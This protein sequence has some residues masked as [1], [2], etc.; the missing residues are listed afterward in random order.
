[1]TSNSPIKGHWKERKRQQGFLSHFLWR[2]SETI[3][4]IVEVNILKAF[5]SRAEAFIFLHPTTGRQVLF[6]DGKRWLPRPVFDL[7]PCDSWTETSFVSSSDSKLKC[8]FFA[9]H[10]FQMLSSAQLFSFLSIMLGKLILHTSTDWILHSVLI[11][12]HLIHAASINTDTFEESNPFVDDENKVDN[13]EDI[14]LQRRMPIEG[15]LLGRRAF[16][17]EGILLGKRAY[18]TEGIL[19]GKRRF[20][21]EGILLGKRAYPMEGILLGKRN[22]RFVLPKSTATNGFEQ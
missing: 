8:Q 15:I 20:P 7:F 14:Q 11:A 9:R 16:P 22:F 13:H 21:S 17:G 1:M 2:K 5:S 3:V 19:L 4:V 18:P 12:L 6:N 10:S